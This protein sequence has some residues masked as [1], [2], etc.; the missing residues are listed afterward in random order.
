MRFGNLTMFVGPMWSGKTEAL[1]KEVVYRNFFVSDA[2]Q[3]SLTSV[4]KSS[5]DDRYG[6]DFIA[7]HEGSKLSAVIARCGQ[8]VLRENAKCLFFDGVEG[9]TEPDFSDD[10]VEIIRVLR[11]QGID[12][13]CSGLDMDDEG[14]PFE[15]TAQLM[16]MASQVNR[17]SGTCIKCGS[18]ATHTIRKKPGGG[19]YKQGGGE[20]YAPV[21][22][23]HW[24][25]AMQRNTEIVIDDIDKDIPLGQHA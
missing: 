20:L 23:E 17:F 10:F 25:E 4:F 8:D 13:F 5:F 14:R 6:V 2:S 21:C 12:V 9:F 16:A 24:F 22:K 1:I 15:I 7:G 11:W 18:S 19:R 3:K